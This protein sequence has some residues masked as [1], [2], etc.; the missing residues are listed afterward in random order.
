[1]S[2]FCFVSRFSYLCFQIGLKSDLSRFPLQCQLP[3]GTTP[4]VQKVWSFWSLCHVLTRTTDLVFAHIF[5]VVCCNNFAQSAN[6][7][8]SSSPY[9]SDIKIT[10]HIF[11]ILQRHITTVHSAGHILRSSAPVYACDALVVLLFLASKLKPVVSFRA[12]IQQENNLHARKETCARF[13]SKRPAVPLRPCPWFSSKCFFWCQNSAGRINQKQKCNN[14]RILFWHLLQ[15]FVFLYLLQLFVL[16]PECHNCGSLVTSPSTRQCQRIAACKHVMR[17][18]WKF[19][20]L[21]EKDPSSKNREGCCSDGHQDIAIVLMNQFSICA[22]DGAMFKVGQTFL[23][24]C[25]LHIFSC[26]F[27]RAFGRAAKWCGLWIGEKNGCANSIGFHCLQRKRQ[28]RAILFLRLVL[29]MF[30]GLETWKAI[31]RKVQD[32]QLFSFPSQLRKREFCFR[33]KREIFG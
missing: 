33:K 19:I 5:S 4:R 25:F 15:S 8:E 24:L 6:L 30:P 28:R 32:D 3:Q 12:Q 22:S 21:Q 26:L 20:S 10:D 27:K 1:M 13:S 16:S 29:F 7:F 18:R 11:G 31:W 2:K 17:T 23:R 9:Q 14:K